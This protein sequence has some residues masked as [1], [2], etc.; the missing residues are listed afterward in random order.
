IPAFEKLFEEATGRVVVS[1]FATSI[2]RLQIVLDLAAESG[3]RVVTVGR[4]MVRNVETAERHAYL[5]VEDGLMVTAQQAKKLAPNEVCL[6]VTGS[7]GEPMSALARMAVG[8][9]K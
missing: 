8:N 4:S 2:H 6:L 3:R 5:D 1:C 9:H 7:Q